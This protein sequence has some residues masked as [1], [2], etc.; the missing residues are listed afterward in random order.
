MKFFLLI[1]LGDHRIDINYFGLALSG[2]PYVCK[3]W[4]SS[5]VIVSNVRSGRVGVSNV[6]NGKFYGFKHIEV[7]LI[8]TITS[9]RFEKQILF[10]P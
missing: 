9:L 5:K 6:F 4:D 1:C 7:L 3:A 2:S 8:N 10:I